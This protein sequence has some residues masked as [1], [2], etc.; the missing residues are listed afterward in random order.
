MV[1]KQKC[2]KANPSKRRDDERRTD[3]WLAIGHVVPSDIKQGQK[4]KVPDN[5]ANEY[6][7]LTSFAGTLRTWRDVPLEP[8]MRTKA[9]IHPQTVTP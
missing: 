7:W 4:G 5:E 8:V 9:G 2:S 1:D 6:C 3:C